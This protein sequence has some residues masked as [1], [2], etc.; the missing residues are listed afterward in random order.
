MPSTTP[1]T[2][3]STSAP[4]DC[5]FLACSAYKFYGPHVGV[6]YGKRDLLQSLE[7]PK[8]GPAPD[9]A[10]ERYETGTQN[11]EGIVGA[12][13]AVDFLASLADG[14]SRRVRLQTAFDALHLRGEA[15]VSRLWDGLSEIAGIRLYGPAPRASRT[16][17]VSFS[18][19]S[20]PALDVCRHL[21]ERGIFATHGDFYATTVVERLGRSREGLVRVGCACYTTED[22]VDR[23]V[24]AVHSFARRAT[25]S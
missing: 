8:L 22:E 4:L 18:V 6:L 25:L 20:H 1:R 2:N 9:S 24:E 17:T 19:R 21:A 14:P 16:P 13:G 5:D 11:H 7:V 15:L 12:A 3:A 23:L 10:P